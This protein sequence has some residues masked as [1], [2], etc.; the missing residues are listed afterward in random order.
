[1]CKSSE[2]EAPCLA[3]PCQHG[4]R[5]EVLAQ[6]GDQLAR[7]NIIGHVLL[8]DRI[9][10]TELVQRPGYAVTDMITDEQKL[11]RTLLVQYCDRIGL[12]RSNQG[13]HALLQ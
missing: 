8:Q 1:V 5:I 9:L 13:I 6:M 12:V 7:A 4:R 11:R 3:A 10:Q 2:P